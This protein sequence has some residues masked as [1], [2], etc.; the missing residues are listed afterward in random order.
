MQ[1]KVE[2]VVKKEEIKV[3]LE[4]GVHAN[5]VVSSLFNF[6][7]VKTE[8][9]YKFQTE[10]HHKNLKVLLLEGTHRNLQN[11]KSFQKMF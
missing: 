4:P 9:G 6:S 10:L 8:P 3:K 1:A 7:T 5:P 11:I 2:N